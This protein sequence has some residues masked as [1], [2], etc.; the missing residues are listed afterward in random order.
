MR[1]RQA[2]ISRIDI[3]SESSS[4]EPSQKD[5]VG[6]KRKEKERQQMARQALKRFASGGFSGTMFQELQHFSG[7]ELDSYP[8][9]FG[10]RSTNC[11]YW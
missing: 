7:A 3:E 4:C 6:A 1:E 5:V 10:Q 2:L 9:L 8:D 11:R